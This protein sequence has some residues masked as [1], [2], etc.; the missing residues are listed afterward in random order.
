MSDRGTE[1][2]EAEQAVEAKLAEAGADQIRRPFQETPEVAAPDEGTPETPRNE[3]GQF[4]A[5]ENV[6]EETGA[7]EEKPEVV[8]ADAPAGDPAVAAFLAKYGGDVDKALEGAVHLQRKAGEQSNEVGELRRMVD[9]LSNLSQAMQSQQP[10]PQLDQATVDWYDTLV[11][12]NPA[13]ALEWARQQNNELLVRHGLSVWKEIDPYEA[14][15]YTNRLETQAMQAEFQQQLQQNQRLPLDATVNL[16]LQNVRNRNPQF[17][18]YDDALEQTLQKH[19]FAAKALEQAANSGD[20]AQIE[21]AI[22]T[23]YSLAVGDTLQSL[24][25]TPP[26]TGETAT[27]DVV[28]PTT[29]ETRDQA[30]EPSAQDKFREQFRQEADRVAKGVWVVGS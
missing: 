25:L 22:E 19:P 10:Q 1:A 5:P 2:L 24:A 9:E 4:V 17:A 23:L 18:N 20:P 21:G 16:A 11:M 12:E 13:Q 8:A 26:P 27:T 7:P 3:L 29:S 6:E 15:V 28:V 14:A 30:P